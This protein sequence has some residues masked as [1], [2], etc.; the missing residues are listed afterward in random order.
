MHSAPIRNNLLVN[1]QINII[2]SVVHKDRISSALL[3]HIPANLMAHV[4]S[5]NYRRVT[6]TAA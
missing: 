4:S 6:H 2:N 5:N 3:A 1:K